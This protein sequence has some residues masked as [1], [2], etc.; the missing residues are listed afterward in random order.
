MQVFISNLNNMAGTATIAQSGVVKI[1][2]NMGY[3]ELG[4]SYFH[5]EPHF[6]RE[7]GNKFLGIFAAF[8]PGDMMIFQYPSWVGLNYDECFVDH[9]KSYKDSKL[10]I[11][12]QDIQKLMFGSEQWVM[13]W[14][15]RTLNKADLLIMPSEK[16]YRKL[17]EN[18]LKESIPVEYQTI[19]EMPGEKMYSEHKKLRKMVFTGNVSRFPF[20]NDYH[21]ATSIDL[22]QR[23]KPNGVDEKSIIYKGFRETNE[24]QKDLAEGGFGL[25]WA[26][27]DYFDSY[28]SM[29]QPHKLGSTLACGIPVIVRKGCAH[30]EF[31]TRN[32]VGYVVSSMEEADMIVQNITD[33]E[34]DTLY[35][36]VAKIQALLLN[37]AYT[38][39][40]LQDSVMRVIEESCK[41][42]KQFDTIQ[43][44]D[45]EESL[46]YILKHH[47]S[48]ARFGDGEFDIMT[49]KSIPYQTYD[50]SLSNELKK[51]VGTESNE[52]LLVCM[53]DVFENLE[54]YNEF[55]VNFWKQHLKANMPVYKSLCKAPW[56]GS[57][58]LSRPYMD[59]ADKTVAGDYFDHLR[60][61]W[62]DKDILIVEGSTSRSGVGNDLF[63]NARSIKRVIGPSRDA[64]SAITLIENE[65][66]NYGKD[67][68]VLLMLGPTAKVISYHLYKEGYWL[69]DMGHI[70]S[71]YE[72]YKQGAVTKVKLPNKH[73]AEHN[74]D[75][76]IKFDD[77]DDYKKQ[78]VSRV[79]FRRK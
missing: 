48:V 14:E 37:G 61:L 24:L 5:L 34:Y 47:C 15:V 39:K 43:V 31:I 30:E 26:G 65:I 51:I 62:N 18:G 56:Y 40:V 71:E 77:D 64:Y 33:E 28:Y 2:R 32:G 17:V 59:L 75:E 7:L 78:I 67:K 20:L 10:I 19:W 35:N 29:N 6:E 12:V 66:R 8:Q 4:I 69:I 13:N 41:K 27:D 60:S 50:E 79:E 42:L 16:L 22:Y 38:R 73:T 11:F 1:A 55:C 3:K 46:N 53:P 54:R 76:N 72:W 70:D 63:S 52:K 57:T 25:V 58:N 36:N 45:N 23:E 21:G 9:V 74:Y 44:I 49:G 68:L